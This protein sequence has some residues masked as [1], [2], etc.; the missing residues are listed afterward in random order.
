MRNRLRS[1]LK[2]GCSHYIEDGYLRYSGRY[3]SIW[4][5]SCKSEGSVRIYSRKEGERGGEGNYNKIWVWDGP[6]VKEHANNS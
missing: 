2:I 3:S 6:L 5:E 1:E 4:G